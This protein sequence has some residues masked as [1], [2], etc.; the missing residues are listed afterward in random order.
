MGGRVGVEEILECL[1][2]TTRSPTELGCGGLPPIHLSDHPLFFFK[3]PQ[4]LTSV[5]GFL[6]IAVLC[7]LHMETLL[8]E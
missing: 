1:S 6:S 8:T 4:L 3:Q 5:M 2:N 7:V